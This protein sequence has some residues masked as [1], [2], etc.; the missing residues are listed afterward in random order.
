MRPKNRSMDEFFTVI[1]I[2][3]IEIFPLILRL[4]SPLVY[5]PHHWSLPHLLRLSR[6]LVFVASSAR[7][8]G[9]TRGSTEPSAISALSLTRF[10]HAGVPSQSPEGPPSTTAWKCQ[11]STEV[12]HTLCASTIDHFHLFL[13]LELVC[14]A[15][16]HSIGH[17]VEI[18]Y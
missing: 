6:C 16:P 14:L 11:L 18:C 12:T 8:S 4:P 9:V 1:Y 2:S 13:I 15:T 10:A 17:T 3:A 7:A 5:S